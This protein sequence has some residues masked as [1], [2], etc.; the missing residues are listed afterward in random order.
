[1]RVATQ[2][3]YGPKSRGKGWDGMLMAGPK[4][5]LA[6]HQRRVPMLSLIELDVLIEL[7]TLFG[8]RSSSSVK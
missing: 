6:I 5:P 1:M 3:V 8:P 2:Y 4:S 7:L